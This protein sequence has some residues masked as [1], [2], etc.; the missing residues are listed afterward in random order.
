MAHSSDHFA[1]PS[2]ERYQM[3]SQEPSPIHK[4]HEES[5]IWRNYFDSLNTSIKPFA[6]K[7][8][9]TVNINDALPFDLIS[10]SCACATHVLLCDVQYVFAPQ[11]YDKVL[12][13]SNS[14][15]QLTNDF[16][17]RTRYVL[18]C[19]IGLGRCISNI[20]E[21]VVRTTMTLKHSQQKCYII[22]FNSIL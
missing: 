17:N 20:C 10:T 18:Q 2:N 12:R 1:F 5:K 22:I 7:Q 13:F 6:V 14:W 19:V 4:N 21:V 9:T 15:K 11:R 3:S 16:V 8:N